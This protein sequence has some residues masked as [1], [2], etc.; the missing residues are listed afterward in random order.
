MVNSEEIKLL[1]IDGIFPSKETIQSDTYPYSV[2]FY[3]IT[4]T[5]NKNENSNLLINWIL[6]EQGQYLIERTGYIPLS[7]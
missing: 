2:I 7:K 3:A 6:S 4:L 1:A 5:D